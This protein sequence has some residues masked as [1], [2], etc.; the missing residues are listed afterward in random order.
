MWNVLK[1]WLFLGAILVLF[2]LVGY[3]IDDVRL[4]W[5]FVVAGLL[6]CIGTY[7]VA[8]RAILGMLGA[9]ELPE[10]EN[11]GFHATVANLAIRAG[12]VKPRIYVIERGPP[13]AL[14]G[15]RGLASSSLGVTSSLLVLPATAEVEGVVAHEL[16]HIR[17]RDIVLQTPV[18]TLS[19]A[20]ID[21][22]RIGGFLERPLLFVLGPVAAAFQ[23]LLLSPKRELR[24]DRLAAEICGSPH[25]L[26]DALTRLDQAAEL[27]EFAASAATE[28]LYTLN[29]FPEQGF[30]GMFASH[31]PVAE[32][33]RRL[34]A[35]DP[36]WHAR[37]GRGGT[38]TE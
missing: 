11:P 24:A 27:V 9:R 14:S 2:G 21:L 12:V 13:L 15:G 8:D 7:W 37:Q 19:A 16:A 10:R 34:R 38:M 23:S 32:R 5:A 20:L 25:G 26:A 36:E 33:V 35:L 3:A 28:P 17:N 22:S 4:A 31:P 29:P 6:F 18:V 30:A 1:A